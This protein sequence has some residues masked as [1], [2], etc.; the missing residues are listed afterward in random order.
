MF[1]EI[2]LKF[3]RA[4]CIQT[5]NE[6]LK[7]ILREVPDRT[8]CDGN[9]KQYIEIWDRQHLI[10]SYDLQLYDIH[11]PVYTDRKRYNF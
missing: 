1:F 5:E 2:W 8:T 4:L 9:I 7:A 10:K 6:K 3:Y 11:G